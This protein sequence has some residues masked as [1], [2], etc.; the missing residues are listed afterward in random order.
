MEITEL[1]V[2]SM[3]KQGIDYGSVLCRLSAVQHHF[4]LR[5]INAV[6]RTSAARP[7]EKDE[8][9]NKRDCYHFEPT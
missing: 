6:T 3:R 1:W 9:R 7:E 2:A 4:K 8:S 5:V